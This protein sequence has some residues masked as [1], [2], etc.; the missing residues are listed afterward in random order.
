MN[1]VGSK[2]SGQKHAVYFVPFHAVTKVSLMLALLVE[3]GGKRL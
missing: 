3:L 1:L 2:L